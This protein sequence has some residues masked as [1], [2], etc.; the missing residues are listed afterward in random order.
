MIAVDYDRLMR[1]PDAELYRVACWLGS[2]ID[3]KELS[4]FR[5]E[6]LDETLRHTQFDP[7]DIY[8]DVAAPMLAREIHGFLSELLASGSDLAV[9]VASDS[10]ARWST[11]LERVYA[12][13]SGWLISKV[14]FC[15]NMYFRYMSAKGRLQP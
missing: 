9:L 7:D 4:V 8:A 11:E 6:F 10:L 5:K 1:D 2:D 14:I 12:R 3:T 13:H 15:T